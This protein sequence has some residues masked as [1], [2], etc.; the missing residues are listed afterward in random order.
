[1]FFNVYFWERER[2]SV[3]RGGR[4]RGTHRNQ[5][6]LQALRC[7]HRAWH[8]P[9]THEPQD[10]DLSQ[11]QMLNW[12]S[13]PGAPKC[14]FNV[15]LFLR[16]IERETEHEW[17]RSREMETESEAGSRLWAVSTEPNLG[18]LY[19]IGSQAMRSW[20]EQGH[21]LTNWATQAPL[22]ILSVS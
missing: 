9:R 7:Q 14:F 5:S 12:L 17:G 18:L 22:K 13:Y 11:S 16:Y 8:R 19:R 15:C 4:D 3:S 21:I 10:H 1:M 2:E 20:P 6:R